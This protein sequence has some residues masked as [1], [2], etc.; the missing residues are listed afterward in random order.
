MKDF[1]NHKIQRKNYSVF[2][3]HNGSRENDLKTKYEGKCDGGHKRLIN[4]LR[5]IS[6]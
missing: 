2:L 3:A 4:L 6:N 1:K 5:K